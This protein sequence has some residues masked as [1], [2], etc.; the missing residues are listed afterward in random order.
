MGVLKG[1]KQ[2]EKFES[3]KQLTRKEAI[4][5]TCYQCNGLDDAAED[6]LGGKSCPLY[7]VSHYC[8]YKTLRSGKTGHLS[9]F[10]KGL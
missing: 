10:K 6:C 7:Q 3:G 5:A 1:Q 4:L 8:G 2:F 9:T